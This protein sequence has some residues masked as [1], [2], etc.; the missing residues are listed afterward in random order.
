MREDLS[1]QIMEAISLSLTTMTTTTTKTVNQEICIYWNIF[2]NERENK[3]FSDEEKLGG[4]ATSELDLRY[5]LKEVVFKR[6]CNIR[7]EEKATYSE[8]IQVNT[9]DFS[10]HF[11]LSKLCLRVE[12]KFFILSDVVLNVYRGN[13]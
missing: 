13:I 3:I 6:T 7:Y 12:A 8:K 2:Q 9:I 5:W 4:F 10:L 1:P 11:K